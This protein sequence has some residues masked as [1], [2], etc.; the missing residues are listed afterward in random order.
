LQTHIIETPRPTT[1][2]PPPEEPPI[3]YNDPSPVA[4]RAPPPAPPA[5]PPVES[6]YN[7]TVDPSAKSLNPPRYPPEESRRGI[8]GTVTLLLTYDISGIITDVSVSKS[9]GN[10]NL[11][12]S[13]MQAARRWKVNPGTRNGQKVAGQATVSVN[14][15][16]P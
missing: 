7:G 11:D 3:V 2:P 1:V 15:S 13:A 8:G 14:F 9:S 6:D 4:Y 16:P 5:P 10:R 12:R